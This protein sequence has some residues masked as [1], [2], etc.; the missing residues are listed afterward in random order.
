MDLKT[1]LPR[2][3]AFVRYANERAAQRA[4]ERMDNINLGVGRNIQVAMVSSKTFL[5]QDESGTM[6]VA[7]C[8]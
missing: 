1:H 8:A 2:G 5:S 6:R 4:V 3:F 7:T